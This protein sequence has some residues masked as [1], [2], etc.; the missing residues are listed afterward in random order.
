MN[1]E[2]W[3]KFTSSIQGRDKIYRFFQ[4]FSR[5]IAFYLAQTGG[6]N[7]QNLVKRL[8]SLSIAIGVARK[9]K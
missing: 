8:Q 4:Y 6:I 5:F 7:K 9:G 1:L 2:Q 3:I